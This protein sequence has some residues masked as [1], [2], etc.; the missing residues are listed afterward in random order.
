MG[1]SISLT[2]VAESIFNVLGSILVEQEKMVGLLHFCLF[3]KMYNISPSWAYRELNEA[4]FYVFS[5]KLCSAAM[6]PQ[7]PASLICC[8]GQTQVLLRL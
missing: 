3:T 1:C 8:Q 6:L 4:G 7:K 5:S 2:Q